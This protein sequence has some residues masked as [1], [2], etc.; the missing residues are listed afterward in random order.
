MSQIVW[1]SLDPVRCKIDIYPNA[2]ATRIEKLYNGRYPFNTSCCV[3]GSDFF[4]ATI[5]FDP[6]GNNYQTTPG[7]YLGRACFKQSGYRSVNRCVVTDG[8]ITIH[9]KQ[10][11]TEWRITNSELE[12]KRTYTVTPPPADIIITNIL[13]EDTTI[14]AWAGDDLTSESLDT[15]VVVWQWCLQT[16]GNISRY[17]SNDWI[18]YNNE[19]NILIEQGFQHHYMNIKINLPVVGVRVIHFNNNSLYASQSSLD[20]TKVRVVRRIVTSINQL[21]EM[22]N[23]ISSIP[24]NYSEIVKNLPDGEVPHHYYCPILQ[25]IMTDPVKT[26]DGFTYERYAIETWFRQKLSSPLTG[27]PLSSDVLVDN[28]DLAVNIKQ[29]IKRVKDTKT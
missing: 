17:S 9:T 27:L 13:K 22:F 12:S 3:L 28:T 1:V 11:D 6:S 14:K 29:F 24:T 20:N 18:P 23:N 4:N 16:R 26:V 8:S 15:L 7:M 19:N 10:V 21:K 25:E 5:H 2:I